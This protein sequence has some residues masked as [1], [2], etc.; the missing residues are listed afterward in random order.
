M[1]TPQNADGFS[2]NTNILTSPLWHKTGDNKGHT[3]P[4]YL[5]KNESAFTPYHNL[6]G[7]LPRHNR[8]LSNIGTLNMVLKRRD[9]DQFKDNLVNNKKFFRITQTA[10]GKRKNPTAHSNLLQDNNLPPEYERI[11]E[12][13]HKFL[14]RTSSGAISGGTIYGNQ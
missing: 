6:V 12:T 8:R 4:K 10:Q 1:S 7:N 5:N 2:G 9:E 14:D 11:Y 13:K 3:D